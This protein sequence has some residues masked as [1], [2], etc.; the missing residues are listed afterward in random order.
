MTGAVRTR[1]GARAGARIAA[2]LIVLGLG[3]LWV[4]RTGIAEHAVDGALAR[5]GVRASYRIVRLGAG[6]QELADVRIGDPAH[7]DLTAR[8]VL[9]TLGIGASG[10]TVRSIAADGVRLRGRI[11]NGTLRLGAIDRLLPPPSGAP[12]ALP[13]LAVAL[14]DTR[15]RLETPAGV[16][17]LAAE[18]T[19]NLADGFAGRI[20]ATAVALRFGGCRIDGPQAVVNVAVARRRPAIDGPVRAAA[21]RCGGASVRRPRLALDTLLAPALDAWDGTALIETDGAA[22]GGARAAAITGRVRFAGD[23]GRTGGVLQLRAHRAAVGGVTGDVGVDGRYRLLAREQA[24]RFAGRADAAGLVVRPAMLGKVTRALGGMA[25]TPL[26]PLGTALAAAIAG[27]A[28]GVDASADLEAQARGPAG[29]VRVLRA[30]ATS[31]SGARLEARAAGGLAFTWPAA[32]ARIDGRATLAGG[33]FPD[34]RVALAQP[35]AGAPMAGEAVIGPYAAVGAGGG[36]RL[37]LAPVRFSAAPGITRFA[38]RATID[39]PLGDGRVARLTL[40]IVGRLGAGGSF[41]IDGGCTPLAFASL[42]IAGLRLG[43]TRLPLCADGR[44]LVW[45]GAGGGVAGGG[46]IAGPRLVGRL[47]GTLVTIAARSLGVAIGHPG[48]V[49][50]ALTVRL[51]AA[52]AVSRLDVAR[53]DGTFGAGGVGGRYAGLGGQIARVPLILSAGDGGW[54]LAHAVLDLAGRLRVADEAAAPRFEPLVSDDARLRLADGKIT[55]GGWLATPATGTRVTQVAIRHDLRA[56]AGDATLAVP[57]IAFTEKLQPE[58]LTKLT[59]GVIANVR[60]TVTGTGRIAWGPQGV[61]S[62]GTF[63]TEAT[64][65]AAAFGPVKG[66]RTTIRFTDLLGLVSAPG[67]E[68]TIAEVNPG[69]GVTQ[70]RARYRLLPDE[71]VA[72]ESARW[73]FAG[74][75]LALEPT[76]LD[77]SAAAERRMTFRVTGMDAA[78]FVQQ[79]DFQNVSVTG[80]FDGAI[81]IVFD[82]RGGRIEH[83]RLA[84]RQGGGTLAY[85]GEISNKQLGLFG[86]LAFDALKKMRYQGLA[87]ELDGSLDGEIV[88]RVLFDGTN[89]TP[90]EAIQKHGLLSQFSNLPFRFRITVRA[91]FRGLLNSA[92]S[93]NDPRGLIDQAQPQPPSPP[94]APLPGSTPAAPAPIQSR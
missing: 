51:G 42:A 54:R 30:S 61:T 53:L 69:I 75:D 37:E 74:G 9:L 7:P 85:V 12:F 71:T 14:T 70:G 29:G 62:S 84:V 27:A 8:R 91:P 77:F 24:G 45:R 83:G 59:L 44:A 28:R 78:K 40:P 60:G 22:G 5:R 66:I 36:A 33:G 17:G 90:R 41:L 19:G 94:Q 13:D 57:G 88:S 73:P 82:A 26:G 10:P 64:D 93:L 55:A 2:A 58:A 92:R 79:F 16:V 38:T 1:P 18:G 49:A 89:E 48:F 81:P 72:V 63:G 46:R 80:V 39:G 67:Q 68:A 32:R 23:A 4:E 47:G 6:E 52:P 15:M 34:V 25:G 56:G 76:L 35:R 43:A 50:D 21:M 86:G 65:L 87:I 31:A 20:A 11:V 3:A